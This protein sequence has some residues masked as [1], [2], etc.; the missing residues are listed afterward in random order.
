MIADLIVLQQSSKEI[1]ELLEDNKSVPTSLFENW[2][3][4]FIF[5]HLKHSNN[6]LD[7]DTS[8][9]CNYLRAQYAYSNKHG[10]GFDLGAV[11]GT[12]SVLKRYEELTRDSE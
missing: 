3:T 12:L 8:M 4:A 6:E 10:E 1:L 11:H 9:L 7:S 2:I 5:T